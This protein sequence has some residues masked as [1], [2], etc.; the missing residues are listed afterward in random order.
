LL[1]AAVEAAAIHGLSRLAVGDVAKRAGLSRQTLYKHFPS[2]EALV[3][4]AVLRE[5]Q[6][7]VG[8][9][10][11]AAEAHDDPRA[12]LEAGIL[13]TLRLTR[14]HP[15]LDRL[16]RTEPESLLPLLIGDEGPVAGAVRAV[17]EQIITRRLPDLTMVETRRAADLLSRLLISYAVSAP[18]DPPEIVAEFIATLVVEGIGAPTLHP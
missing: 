1:D 14:E 4:E 15:L 8:E 9:I 11:A 18:D 6:A 2:K 10:V 5:A 12:S 7:M 16:I 3:A 13:V 17:V